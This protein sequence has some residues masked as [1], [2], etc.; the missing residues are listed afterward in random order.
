MNILTAM[1]GVI[2]LGIAM[3]KGIVLIQINKLS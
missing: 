2:V 1:K 3:S